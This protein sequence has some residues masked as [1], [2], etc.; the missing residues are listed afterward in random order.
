MV[1][2]DLSPVAGLPPPKPT[3]KKTKSLPE[4]DL[5]E[6]YPN[7]SANSSETLGVPDSCLSRFFL[8]LPQLVSRRPV[9]AR[10]AR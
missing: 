9:C 7:R 8:F 6:I 5:S 3:A 10:K 4:A 2:L 1:V